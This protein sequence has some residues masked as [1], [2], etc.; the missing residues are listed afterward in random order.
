MAKPTMF[1]IHKS[2]VKRAIDSKGRLN[3]FVRSLLGLSEK[4]NQKFVLK[5]MEWIKANDASIEWDDDNNKTKSYISK[6]VEEKKQGDTAI[7]VEFLSELKDKDLLNKIQKV[8]QKTQDHTVSQDIVITLQTN[9]EVQQEF[10]VKNFMKEEVGLPNLLPVVQITD[11]AKLNKCNLTEKSCA[12]IADSFRKY[13]SSVKVLDMSENE[14]GDSGVKDIISVL[15]EEKCKIENLSL[16]YCGLTSE[17]CESL[18]EALAET[19]RLHE[20]NLS[21]N[22]IHD[23]GVFL[24]SMALT[25]PKCQLHTLRLASCQLSS[26]CCK[27]LSSSL[28]SADSALKHL[29][30]SFN[31]LQDSGVQHLSAAPTKLETLRLAC[32]NL[33]EGSG[34]HLGTLLQSGALR[35][36]DLTNNML[37]D[38]GLQQLLSVGLASQT[39]SLERLIIKKCEIT[40]QDPSCCEAVLSCMKSKKG[41]LRELDL[42]YNY[43]QD[44]GAQTVIPSAVKLPCRIEKLSLAC[45][46]LTEKMCGLLSSEL[47]G[48]GLM[49]SCLREIDFSDNDLGS[50]GVALL[51]DTL[52][53]DACK[54]E[55]L[56]L[57]QC[58][59]KAPRCQDLANALRKNPS[60]MTVLD[61]RFNHLEDDGSKFFK[62]LQTNSREIKIEGGGEFCLRKGEDRYERSLTLDENTANPR[63]FLTET[64]IRWAEWELPLPVHLDRFDCR[65]QVLCVE[66]LSSRSYWEVKWSGMASVGVAYASMGRKGENNAATLG[67][68]DRSWCLDCSAYTYSAWHG[69]KETRVAQQ[70]SGCHRL[71]VYLDWLGGTLAFFKVKTVGGKRKFTLLHTF[72]HSFSLPLLPGFRI[73]ADSSVFICPQNGDKKAA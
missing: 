50:S 35:D 17:T 68:N 52:Q 51:C 7:L 34:H 3:I 61:L 36:L 55:K 54:W 43:L 26:K 11:Q 28:Q 18:S 42:S 39:C 57:S 33:T 5:C 71:G 24:L 73:W 47:G 29:D 40:L 1:D 6:K 30:L 15:H 58:N 60:H 64:K 13:D 70:P 63:L 22:N 37:K 32:C 16:S 67:R 21:N 31:D 12:Q 9:K 56:F 4:S 10:E 48:E 27:D 49:Q 19:S 69:N 38:S 20:L 14:L 62:S 46:S 44:S 65:T 59:I 25:D 66:A 72:K 41:H 45:C 2:A 23:Q 8:N 53:K